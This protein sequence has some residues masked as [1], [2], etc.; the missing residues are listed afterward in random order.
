MMKCLILFNGLLKEMDLVFLD[1]I[2]LEKF[3]E[4]KMK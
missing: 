4:C 3:L 1:D 2:F